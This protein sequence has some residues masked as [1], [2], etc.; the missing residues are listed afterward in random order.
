[1]NGTRD[2]ADERFTEEVLARF[3]NSK[4]PRYQEVMRSLVRHLHAFASEVGLTEEERST[5]PPPPMG[6]GPGST[7]SIL[8]RSGRRGRR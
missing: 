7:P 6:R 5:A 4:S 8:S 1:M 3:E 2:L